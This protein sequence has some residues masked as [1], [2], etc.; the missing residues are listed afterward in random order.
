MYQSN[1]YKSTHIFHD[2]YYVDISD[3]IDIK[4]KAILAHATEVKKFGPDWL[5]FWIYEAA[6]NG[7]KFN[8][9]YAEAFQPVK[10][11]L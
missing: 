2:T 6:N 11:L 8:V 9:K 3:Y 1:L 10:V 4:K 7:K 5:N